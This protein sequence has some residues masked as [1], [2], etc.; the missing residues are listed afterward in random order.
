MADNINFNERTGKYSFVS[1]IELPWHKL[2]QIVEAMTSKE[3]M[4]LGGLDFEVGLRPIYIAGK[5]ILR[6]N[7]YTVNNV[8]KSP[9]VD[10]INP[11]GKGYCYNESVTLKGK[12][13]TVRNDNNF[14][15]GIVGSRYHPIQNWEAFDFFDRVIGEGNAQ[16]ETAGVLGNGETVFITAK[17]PNYIKVDGDNIDSY[18]LLTM[19][20]DGSGAIQAMFTPVRVVCN[21]T[22]SFALR[23]NSNKVSIRHTKSAKEKLNNLEKV[24]GMTNSITDELNEKFKMIQDITIPDNVIE[25]LLVECLGLKPMLDKEEFSTKSKNILKDALAY[26]KDGF[27]QKEIH[28]TGYGVLNAV[29]GYSQNVKSFRSSES[30]FNSM[31]IKNGATDAAGIRQRTFDLLLNSPRAIIHSM[32]TNVLN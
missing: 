3:A 6:N 23:N 25:G 9:D 7:V 12:F 27:G 32:T 2:G 26:Y 4:E 31:F 17:L 10:L 30:K 29:T 20:H 1:K 11:D 5:H 24:M 15:L 14:P 21:N 19:A 22:L 8:I 16:Y 18:L 28:G 13:A